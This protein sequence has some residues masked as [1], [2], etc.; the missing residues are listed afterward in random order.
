MYSRIVVPVDGSALAEQAFPQVIEMA[1][2]FGIPVALVRVVDVSRLDIYGQSLHEMTA[3]RLK[4]AIA[5]ERHAAINYLA[6]LSTRFADRGVAVTTTLRQGFVN[7]VLLDFVGS[8]DLLVLATRAN[9]GLDR[10]HLGSTA[11]AM[12]QFARAPVLVIPPHA[13]SGRMSSAYSEHSSFT[14]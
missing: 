9:S 7:Q 5:D 14:S 11:N 6:Q 4:Q 3:E 13:F 12:I 8:N 1:K 2:C 10:S